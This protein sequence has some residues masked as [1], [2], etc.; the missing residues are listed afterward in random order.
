MSAHATTLGVELRRA[1]EALRAADGF[2]ADD[3]VS[4]PRRAR[5]LIE[6]ARAHDQRAERHAVYVL[7]DKSERTAP[8]TIRYNGFAREMLLGL[9]NHPPVGMRAE[10]RDLRIV[11]VVISYGVRCYCPVE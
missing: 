6:V 1:G 7:L 5:H 9:L 8:E 2:D 10:V 4:V 3:I 11:R